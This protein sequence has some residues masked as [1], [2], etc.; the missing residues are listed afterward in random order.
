M[1]NEGKVVHLLH[2]GTEEEYQLIC[3]LLKENLKNSEINPIVVQVNGMIKID[4]NGRYVVNE[5]ELEFFTSD[6]KF[7]VDV[8]TKVFGGGRLTLNLFKS[9]NTLFKLK[10]VDVINEAKKAADSQLTIDGFVEEK[11]ALMQLGYTKAALFEQKSKAAKFSSGMTGMFHHEAAVVDHYFMQLKI[12]EA[13]KT[14]A[15]APS[16]RYNI[17]SFI[18]IADH[19]LIKE[20]VDYVNRFMEVYEMKDSDWN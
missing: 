5:R 13:I 14:L 4:H 8:K 3:S 12:L 11:K 15:A 20:C 10:L 18:E 17:D 16:F 6:I 2:T 9:L 1:E 7:D 19:N